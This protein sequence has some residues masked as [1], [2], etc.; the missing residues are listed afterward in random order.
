MIEFTSHLSIVVNVAI[1]YFTSNTFSEVFV[2]SVDEQ[3]CLGFGLKTC[4]YAVK[5]NKLFINSAGFL[6]ALIS[7][8]HIVA[9]L[10]FIFVKYM[11]DSGEFI[12][13][14]RTNDLLLK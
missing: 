7:V 6:L 5:M 2:S 3:V 1:I 8:E 14:E 12:D 11:D 13:K 9:F 4:F 10:K